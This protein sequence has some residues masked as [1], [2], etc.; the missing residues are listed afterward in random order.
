MTNKIKFVNFHGHSNASIFDGLGYPQEHLEFAFENG[1]EAIALTDHGNMNNMVYQ[2]LHAKKMNADG[3]PIKPIFGVEAYFTPSIEEWSAAYGGDVSTK[4]NSATFIEDEDSKSDTDEN[5]VEEAEKLKKR[6]LNRRRHLVLLA[7]NQTGLYNI[8]KLISLSF[9]SPNFYR[10]PRVDYKM[11][12]EHSEGI[13]ATSACLGGIYAGDYWEHRDYGDEAVLEAMRET[14]K[15]MINIFGDDWYGE[16]QWNFIKEQHEV[17]KHVIQVCGELDIKLVS[18]A[19]AHFPRP[20]LWEFREMYKRLGWKS[21]SEEEPAKTVKELGYHLYPKNGEQMFAEY[22][23]TSEDLGFEYDHEIVLDSIERTH[24][25]AFEKIEDFEPNCEVRLPSFMMKEEYGGDSDLQLREAVYEALESFGD[26][27][28]T[29]VY[30][31][32]IERELKV[33]KDTNFSKYFI[34]MDSIV[35]IAQ[36]FQLTGAGRGSVGGCLIAYI[37]GITEIDS[38]R[39]NTQFERFM[40][41]DSKD[42]PDIDY[43]VEE[44]MEFKNHLI[45]LWGKYSV[46]PISTSSKLKLKSLI[47]S[48]S[49]SYDIDFQEVNKV[50]TAIDK[51]AIPKAKA[52]HGITA[53]V[54]DP[55]FEEYKEYSPSLEKFLADH[56]E[57]ESPIKAIFAQPF[58]VGRHAGGVVISENLNEVMPLISSKGVIQT[59]WSEGQNVR[60]LEPM[61]FIKFDLLGLTTLRMIRKCIGEILKSN[62]GIE[63]PSFE[64]IKAFYRKNLH[65]D[66]IDVDDQ[67]VY[68]GGSFPSVFQFTKKNAQDFCVSIQPKNLIDISIITSIYRPGPLT[69][70]VDVKFAEARK[71]P[72]SIK[73][74]HPLLKEITE[75]TSGFLVFQ[76]QIAEIAH[77]LGKDINLD[78]ANQLRKVLTKK[79]TGKED[80]VKKEL[81]E[82]FVK[83]CLEHG[84]KETDGQ[85]LWEEME[86]FS[87]YGFN[88]SHAIAYSLLSFQCAWLFTY[89]PDEWLVAIL[90]ASDK[91]RFSNMNIAKNIGYT[92]SPPNINHSQKEWHCKDKTLY[93]PLSDIKGLGASAWDKIEQNRPYEEIEDLLFNR[94]KKKGKLNIS[95]IDNMIKVGALDELYDSRFKSKMHF[96]AVCVSKPKNEKQFNEFLQNEDLM[97]LPDFTDDEKIMHM[98]ELT[99]N[100][101]IMSVLS[102]EMLQ[103]FEEED[104]YPI[105][106]YE[107]DALHWFVAVSKEDAKTKYGKVYWKINAIDSSFQMVKINVWS[108]SERDTL[109]LNRAYIVNGLEFDEKWGY[110]T[111]FKA[112]FYKNYEVV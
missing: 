56:P 77:K 66:N 112:P 2:F 9:Q 67:K 26:E 38:I 57:V 65:I 105:S 21:K 25:I 74:L 41:S 17:N 31:D 86:F 33:L 54:Y 109:H 46:V 44:P 61:G 34:A 13:I 106:E 58:A 3:R 72:D 45:D 15:K 24:E 8:F 108:C 78:E 107:E 7:K 42:M 20:E 71:N 16:L 5:E 6:I 35:S 50:T 32:R 63:E 98:Y 80:K 19:D 4:L 18:T 28:K 110:S 84:L 94:A 92:I 102:E 103:E 81:H 79:G 101:P 59:P 53:G 10:F 40:R 27:Y 37:L 64:E 39:W 93:Q 83:G 12:K 87:G 23:R 52:F 55:T 96:W 11:L 99:K 75:S 43:D 73:Y 104:I 111:G 30:I 91:E 36:T 51:E 95:N 90:A 69:A 82:K 1:A 62:F 14:S 89:Y 29:K 60:H 85:T 68:G 48:I 97:N 70:N 76:E 49:K 100:Y 22:L 88:K 47:K